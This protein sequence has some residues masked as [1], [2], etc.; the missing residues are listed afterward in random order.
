MYKNV[1]AQEM[2]SAIDNC[3]HPTWFA[4]DNGALIV[5]LCVNYRLTDGKVLFLK[6]YNPNLNE[7]R[8]LAEQ[9]AQRAIKKW[10]ETLLDMQE[11]LTRCD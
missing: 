5:D 11:N 2:L 10:N 7:L 1:T 3:W 4:V 9:V 6:H 8:E